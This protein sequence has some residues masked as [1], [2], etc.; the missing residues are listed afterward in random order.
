[1]PIEVLRLERSAIGEQ[2]HR[3]RPEEGDDGVGRGVLEDGVVD[4]L[5]PSGSP[6]RSDAAP[7][8]IEVA[9]VG[10]PAG[11]H[12]EVGDDD[13]DDRHRDD[14]RDDAPVRGRGPRE[15][16]PTSATVAK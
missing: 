7:G 11:Q 4:R 2:R 14:H 16:R 5:R 1:M 8:T 9:G 15:R 3:P 6:V 13:R 10:H 12:D